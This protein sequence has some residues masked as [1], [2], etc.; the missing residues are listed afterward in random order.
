MSLNTGENIKIIANSYK[1][2]RPLFQVKSYLY[3]QGTSFPILVCSLKN[4]Y[5]LSNVAIV[6]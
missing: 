6:P 5:A 2:L 4:N 1:I 3:A